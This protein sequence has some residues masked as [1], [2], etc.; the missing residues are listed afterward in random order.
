[1]NSFS[2]LNKD[3]NATRVSAFPRFS[4]NLIVVKFDQKSTFERSLHRLSADS[5]MVIG[6][7]IDPKRRIES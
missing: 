1:M 5:S 4:E 7:E 6:R 2:E 3:S